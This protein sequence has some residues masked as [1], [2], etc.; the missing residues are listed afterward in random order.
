MIII[1]TVIFTKNDHTALHVVATLEEHFPEFTEISSVDNIADAVKHIQQSQP[2][3]LIIDID[4]ETYD[5]YQL[6]EDLKPFHCEVIFITK[7]DMIRSR[8]MQCNA[9]S[10]LPL[11]FNIVDLKLSIN[12]LYEKINHSRALFPDY[13]AI[14]MHLQ[15]SVNRKL[16]LFDKGKTNLIK[17]GNIAYLH[18]DN[19]Y[20]TAYLIDKTSF[21]SSSQL[22]EI[23]PHLPTDLFYKA[24]RSYIVN[25]TAI[26]SHFIKNGE[27][28]L[29][30]SNGDTIPLSNSH[31]AEILAII[32]QSL[33]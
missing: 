16:S 20:T 29:V 6:I 28:Y 22:G 21:T 31:K 8:Y 23:E 3:L 7:V 24:H 11:P 19:G 9:I 30:M 17:M 26:E 13:V 18:S 10:C 2:N 25:I 14:D 1:K 4:Y 32:K 27:Y 33:V 5:A 12:K 15:H